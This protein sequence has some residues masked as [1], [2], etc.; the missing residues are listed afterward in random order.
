MVAGVL[1]TA[2]FGVVVE[3]TIISG[4]VPNWIGQRPTVR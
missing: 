2:G 3:R 1:V 4:F